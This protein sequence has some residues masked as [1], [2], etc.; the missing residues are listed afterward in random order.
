MAEVRAQRF[1]PRKLGNDMA[2]RKGINFNTLTFK[3][4]PECGKRFRPKGTQKYCSTDC[5]AEH[6]R[7]KAAEKKVIIGRCELCGQPFVKKH[8]REHYCS[9]RCVLEVNGKL[10]KDK[11]PMDHESIKERRRL[12]QTHISE[13]AAKAVKAGLS[14]GKYGER[15]LIAA[16]GSVLDQ[17]WAQELMKKNNRQP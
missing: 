15:E 5:K 2:D 12:S 10:K 8:P 17:D 11:C 7:K 14:Y 3:A 9:E 16:A 1:G 6:A 13:T 4:C